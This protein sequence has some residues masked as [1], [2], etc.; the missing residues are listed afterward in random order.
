MKKAIWVNPDWSRAKVYTATEVISCFGLGCQV[1][2]IG[3][4]DYYTLHRIKATGV[5]ADRA[6]CVHCHPIRQVPSGTNL[7][8][9][10]RI[11]HDKDDYTWLQSHGGNDG[12]YIG[13][14]DN[15]FVN[16]HGQVVD[17]RGL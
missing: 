11:N 17:G 3:V 9:M 14:G 4:G 8:E 6:F 16:K 5:K 12:P 1:R 10:W 13:I 15:K 7:R 2:N